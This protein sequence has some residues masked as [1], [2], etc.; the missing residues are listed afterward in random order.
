M[1]PTHPRPG[2]PEPQRHRMLRHSMSTPLPSTHHWIPASS[3]A[4]SASA[5]GLSAIDRQGRLARRARAPDRR[6]IF[7]YRLHSPD[8]DDLGEATYAKMIKPCEEITP[9]AT[10]TPAWSTWLRSRRRTNRRSS[11]CY[12]SRSR[13]GVRFAL[14]TV[15]QFREARIDQCQR[16]GFSRQLKDPRWVDDAWT[17]GQVACDRRRKR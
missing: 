3:T 11:G 7:R 13:G 14:R 4:S 6:R 16:G 10:N 1:R 17:G 9:A 15:Q 5:A 8:G 12:K 2:W